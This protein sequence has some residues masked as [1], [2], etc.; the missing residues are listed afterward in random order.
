[1][2]EN[3]LVTPDP[4][5]WDACSCYKPTVVRDEDGSYHLWYNGRVDGY[6]YIGYAH[7]RID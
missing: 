1:V 7:G 6:E 4:G 2:P 5:T 3:P